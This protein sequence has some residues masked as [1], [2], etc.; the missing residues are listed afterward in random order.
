MISIEISISISRCFAQLVVAFTCYAS[1]NAILP[2]SHPHHVYPLPQAHDP[3]SVSFREKHLA[4][5][6]VLSPTERQSHSV[7]G[8]AGPILLCDV[9]KYCKDRRTT[10]GS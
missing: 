4:R 5:D 8:I 9:R 7:I 10:K 1:C 3:A 6:H 2:M